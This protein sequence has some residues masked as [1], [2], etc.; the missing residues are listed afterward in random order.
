MCY[1]EVW[2][3]KEYIYLDNAATTPCS[4]EVIKTMM[5]YWNNKYANPSGIYE[6][7][8]KVK[9]DIEN[10][11]KNIA[12][13]IGAK[14]DEIYF[15]SGGSES[16]NMAIKAGTDLKKM[17]GRHIITSQIEHHAVI[18]SCK[19]IEKNGYEVTY[20]PVNKEGIVNIYDLERAIR[21]D[22]IMISIMFVNNE[23]GTIQPIK[24]IGEICREYGIMFHTDAVQAYTKIPIDVMELNIDMLSV[25][26]HKIHGPKGCGFIYINS[27][28]N[29][30]PI[31]SGGPQERE[32]RAGTENVPGIVG[33]SKAVTLQSRNMYSKM[34]Y[35]GR[36]RDY[37]QAR[38][39]SEIKGTKING[40]IKNRLYSNINICFEGV[41]GQ[42][43][44][45]L[46][47]YEGICVSTGSAC[48][49][50]SGEPS[51][52]LKA[53]GLTDEEAYSSIRITLDEN[54]NK[55]QIDYAIQKIKEKVNILRN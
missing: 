50:G 26:G 29:I 30:K 28:Y 19:Y 13:S 33:M 37:M 53:I 40:S 16:D 38:I 48:N 43:L 23:I 45:V 25:S 36:L 39:L 47:S 8:K 46:L 6:M 10:A 7:S 20:L 21:D 24:E 11:R 27:K 34:E 1:K 52:V 2:I 41:D 31:I 44:A 49:Y 14:E 32:K 3:L 15:T 51:H 22:T 17:E 55:N 42:S 4:I 5:P 35:V 18:N 9:N 54:I 12:M